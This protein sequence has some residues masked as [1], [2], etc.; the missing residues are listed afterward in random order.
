MVFIRFSKA[1]KKKYAKKMAEADLRSD[2]KMASYVARA[3]KA[4]NELRAAERKRLGLA[5]EL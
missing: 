4:F 5:D 3:S 1:D 2:L